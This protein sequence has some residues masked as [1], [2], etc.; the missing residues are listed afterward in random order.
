MLKLLEVAPAEAAVGRGQRVA[1]PALL[2]DRVLKVATPPLAATVRGA[3]QGA[4]GR[5]GADGHGDVGGVA[6][7]QV[8]E[9]VEHLHR[10]R[11]A[12]RH[13]RHGVGRLHAE[14]QVL[15]G[16]AVMLKLLEV[17]PVRL[18]SLAAQRV[19]VPALLMDR[20]LKVAMPPTG[21]HGGRAAQG[22]AAGVGADGHRHVGVSLVTR[23]P[24][25]SST[26]TV[27][28]GLI[29]TPATVLVGCTPK[30]RWSAAAGVMLK[31]LEV[32]PL[33]LLSVARQRVAGAGLVDRQVLKVAMP[34]L[35]ATVIVPL[36]VP[37]PAIGADG[38]GHVRGV[39]GHQ[40]AELV[41]HL[42]RHR[43]ADRHAGTALVGC[44][45]NAR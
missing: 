39:A 25:W 2:M 13:A 10:H 24:N 43:R 29:G 1:V 7:D 15:G 37:P 40:V 32:A 41:E 33:R 6:G 19:A 34:P 31:V 23:L 21:R 20:L 4:A 30:A 35:A 9:L 42:H 26:C 5:V 45:K 44:C 8:A 11:R 12:D 28:A 27:T 36:R 3:A 38:H 22:A 17:A 14:D 18:P 16:A